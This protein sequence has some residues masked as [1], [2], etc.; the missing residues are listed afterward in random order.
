MAQPVTNLLINGLNPVK[1]GGSSTSVQFFPYVPGA[2]IGVTSTKNG[3]LY[4]PGNAEANGQRLTVRASGN[5]VTS[6]DATSP[7]IL[8]GLYAAAYNANGTPNT[9]AS[10]LVSGTNIYSTA[11]FSNTFTNIPPQGTT[12]SW[13]LTVDLVGDGLSGQPGQAGFVAS[14][15]NQVQ[16]L[17]GAVVL[18]GTSASASAGLV[19]P[20]IPVNM[21]NPVP[22]GLAIGFTFSVGAAANAASLFQ[23][24]IQQ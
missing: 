15:S 19:T 21:N 16:L 17:S 6:G 7:S 2:S 18:D 23:F 22:F 11:I 12:Q 9:T 14:G 10:G 1:L 3:I 4:I 20:V 5:C 24:D 8:I 13:A